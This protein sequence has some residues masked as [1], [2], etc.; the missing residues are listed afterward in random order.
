MSLRVVHPDDHPRPPRD[1][2]VMRWLVNG[3]PVE[4]VIHP[5]AD[6]PPAPDAQVHPSS[7]LWVTLRAAESPRVSRSRVH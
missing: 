7:G 3:W 6:E 5:A 4:L 2:P 1:L